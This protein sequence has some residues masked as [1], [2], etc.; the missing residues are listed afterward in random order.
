[1]ASHIWVSLHGFLGTVVSESKQS[2]WPRI[3]GMKTVILLL[4]Y[5]LQDDQR[6]EKYI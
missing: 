6:F 1:M 2:K 5:F 4:A 3:E